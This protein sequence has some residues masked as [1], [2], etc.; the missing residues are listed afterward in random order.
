MSV[1]CA[2]IAG[3]LTQSMA[4]CMQGSVHALGRLKSLEESVEQD[5][6]E[7]DCISHRP[8]PAPEKSAPAS[9][10]GFTVP[11][12]CSVL[13]AVANIC[14]CCILVGS[15]WNNRDCVCGS[16]THGM[17]AAMQ[18]CAQ[19]AAVIDVTFGGGWA[20]Q[21][22]AMVMRPQLPAVGLGGSPLAGGDGGV[23]GA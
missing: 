10:D 21:T 3:S 15:F 11:P 8:L 22:D 9:V 4:S 1:R 23:G 20:A 17:I 14:V 6:I 7:A 2:A 19:K 13:H 5:A 16:F 18:G 12:A